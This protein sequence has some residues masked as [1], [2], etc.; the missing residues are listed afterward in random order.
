M[1]IHA[2]AISS[3]APEDYKLIESEHLRLRGTIDNLR[4]TCFNVGN[5]RGCT[6]CTRE[7]LGTCRGRL[8]SFYYNIMDFSTNH[9]KHEESIMLKWLRHENEY[10]DF[11]KH[12]HAHR[13]I[14]HELAALVGESAVLDAQGKTAECYRRL[15][16]GV[17]KLFEDHELMFDD[18]FIRS[19]NPGAG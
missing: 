3:L 14:L 10:K 4:D 18:P 6:E 12:Q 15:F 1:A 11:L 8:V 13:G 2:G 19:T 16:E 17:G 7:K 5:Q 9:F